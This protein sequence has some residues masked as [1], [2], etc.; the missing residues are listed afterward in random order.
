MIRTLL[1]ILLSA[2]AINVAGQ[3]GTEARN[4]SGNGKL[5]LGYFINPSCQVG[6]IAGSNTVL[7]TIGVGVVINSK[8]YVSLTYKYIATENTPDGEDS[9]LY[10]DEQFVGVRCELSVKPAKEVHINFPVEVGISHAELDIKD[11]Y[12]GGAFAVPNDD[13]SFGYIEPGVG[14]EINPW[15]YIKVNFTAG[16]RFVNRLSFRN[17]T[18]NDLMGVTLSAGLKIGLF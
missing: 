1:A 5:H 13:A 9:K 14:I 2:I 4:L 11:S 12:E 6:R 17:L 10:L 7:P 16:Y 8:F 15:K 3:T 18:E